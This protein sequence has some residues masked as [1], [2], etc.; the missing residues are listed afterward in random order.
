MNDNG[1]H[2]R[3]LVADDDQNIADLVRMYLA[4]AGYEAIVA[5]DGD[6]TQKLLREQQF[7]LLILDIMMPGPDGLQIIRALRRRS[8][9]PVIFVT[10]R[11]SDIDRSPGF[12]W[13]RT[14]TSPSRSTRRSSSRACSRS[15]GAA[16]PAAKTT[17]RRPW[18]R[19]N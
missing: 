13:A 5:R 4:K 3:I 19:V 8:E 12:R 6:E 1:A 18:R 9:L 2:T 16:A 11:S 10:A 15:C 17:R 14:T 7:D